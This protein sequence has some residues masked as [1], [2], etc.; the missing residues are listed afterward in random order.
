M[1]TTRRSFLRAVAVAGGGM[2][3]SLYQE[4]KAAARQPGRGGPPLSPNAFI[5]IRPDGSVIIMSRSPEIGQGI[6]TT[7]PMLIAEELDVEWKSVRVEQ[8]DLDAKYGIQ[9]TGGSFATPMSWDPMRR[10][11]A[12]ARSML[13]SAAASVWA[14][15]PAEC[16]TT[17]GHVVHDATK[18]VLG[19]GELASRAAALPLPDLAALKLKDSKDYRIIG[20]ATRGVDAHA[21]V[22]GKQV[23]G[24]DVNLPGM[25]YAVYEKCPVFGGTVL[26]SNV[27]SVSKLP[28]VRHA[29]K[30]DAAAVPGN[31]LPGDPGLEPG[32]AIVADTWWAAQSA[33]KKLKVTWNEGRWATQSSAAFERAAIEHAKQAP[34]KTV[35]NDGDAAATLVSASKVIEGAYAY[36]FIAHAPLEPQNCT[37][38]Y[39]DGKIEIWSNSQIP[40]SGRAMVA[41]QL[42]LPE[43]NVTVHVERAGGGFGR[44]LTNDYMVEAAVIAKAV[45]VPV[46][47]LW[48]R[49]DDFAHDYYRPGGFQFLKAGLDAGG[50][51]IAWKNHFVT[52]GEGGRYAPSAG[53][54]AEFPVHFVPNFD[55]GTTA[56]PLGIRTGA[57]RAPGSNAYAF[58]IQSFIDELAHAAGKDP[59]EFRISLLESPQSGPAPAGGFGP[60]FNPARMLAVLKRVADISGWGKT[61]P[62]KGVGAGVAFYYSHMGYFAEV[63]HVSVSPDKQV[64]VEQVWVSG[65]IGSKIINPGAAENLVQGAI[66]DGL[67]ELMSQEIT[68]EKGRVVQTN[69]H[70]HGMVNMRQ[71]PPHIHVD[72]LLTDNSPTGLGEPALPPILPAVCNAIFA[73]TGQRIRSLPLVKHG[74]S[75]G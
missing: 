63:A 56:M 50:K 55:L 14:V 62:A 10:V 39:K 27:E 1:E 24:I 3:L 52:Y 59:V 71:A 69:Y 70:M 66:I 22:T 9:F 68:L 60:P 2:L 31:V 57:L 34:E 75:W 40:G 15:P 72:F 43:T 45:G 32:V 42:G 20:H 54:G 58:V 64:K 4:Q 19:Y 47:L 38:H 36:P 29:F 74:Y 13:I 67:S 18:R 37:A 7:L 6:K 46:K 28:G 61:K 33:R 51:L 30:V 44:R 25:L 41:K 11:G 16:S 12:A 8:A 73:A 17:P 65:D 53:M 21:I 48:S 35:R 49:E 23:F 5:E 26:S